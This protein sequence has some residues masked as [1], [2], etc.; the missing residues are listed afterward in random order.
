MSQKLTVNLGT[1]P[2]DGQILV[3]VDAL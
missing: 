2:N 3:L 1:R